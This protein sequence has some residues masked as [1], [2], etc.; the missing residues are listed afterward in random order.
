VESLKFLMASRQSDVNPFREMLK[1]MGAFGGPNLQ[2]L[3]GV[4]GQQQDPRAMPE[5][6]PDLRKAIAML[7]AKGVPEAEAIAQAKQL[8]AKVPF[9]S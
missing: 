4:Q 8:A 2:E 7:M 6:H 9:G 5:R 3:G 1:Q